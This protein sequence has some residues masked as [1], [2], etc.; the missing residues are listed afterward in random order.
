MKKFVYGML[1]GALLLGALLLSLTRHIIL[2]RLTTARSC[3]GGRH[4][5]CAP[6]KL[7]AT[8]C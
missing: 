7:S 6:D 8:D 4:R 5:G 1:A 3:R 2:T